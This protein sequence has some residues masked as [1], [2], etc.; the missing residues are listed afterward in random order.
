MTIA[1]GQCIGCRL[2]KSKEWAIRCV[3]EAQLHEKNCFI[4]LTYNNEN[5]PTDGNLRVR[6]FQLFMK[7]LRSKHPN[8]KIRFF[9]C[10][11]YG[12]KFSRPHYHAA[13]FNFDFE[14]KEVLRKTRGTT[15]WVS[16]ELNKIWGKGFATIGELNFNSAAYI[17]RYITK[18][19]TG[20]Q[21]EEHYEQ[22]NEY[23]ELI[24]RQ[25]EYITM[26]R[27]PGIAKEWVEKYKS[28]VYPSDEVIINGKKFRPPK[29]Y[30]RCY[31]HY[32]QGDYLKLKAKRKA[33]AKSKKIQENSTPE[34]LQVREKIQMLKAKELKRSYEN[35]TEDVHNI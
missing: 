21:A 30:D 10:G 23:G 28:D 11:E 9:H 3:H 17:A 1:C 25:K 4:T 7:K 6:D 34:R 32:Y 35:G 14:D 19:I 31:E 27:R 5:L 2:A 24:Q 13:L 20:A 26:S 33:K 15:L 12:E 8:E 16:E 18:K 29:Y 22:M